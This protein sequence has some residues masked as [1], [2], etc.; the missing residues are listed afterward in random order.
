MEHVGIGVTANIHFTE[1][2]CPG[3]LFLWDFTSSSSQTVHLALCLALPKGKVLT[4]Q[5]QS[6][7]S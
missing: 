5:V 7:L 6:G 3:I 2:R 4:Q 1:S